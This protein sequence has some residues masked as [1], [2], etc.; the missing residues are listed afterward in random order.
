VVA[1]GHSFQVVAAAGVQAKRA[2][3]LEDLDRRR[4]AGS[5]R[6]D[7]GEDLS[8]C[9]AKVDAA[10]RVRRPVAH[11]EPLDDDDVFDRGFPERLV[12]GQRHE[13]LCCV[14]RAH[15]GVPRAGSGAALEERS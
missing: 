14:D 15:S 7:E 10:D 8:V 2:S 3:A 13:P 6:A 9:D 12:R 5:V 11:A 4:L 1:I